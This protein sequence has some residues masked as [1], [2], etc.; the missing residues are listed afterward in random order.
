MH[1]KKTTFFYQVYGLKTLIKP[2]SGRTIKYWG[3]LS[4][5]LAF[6]RCKFISPSIC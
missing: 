6:T 1:F 4:L 5:D 2:G 3:P